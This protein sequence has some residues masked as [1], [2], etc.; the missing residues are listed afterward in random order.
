MYTCFHAEYGQKWPAQCLIGPQ[1][2]KWCYI[3]CWM[4]VSCRYNVYVVFRFFFWV[5]EPV[6]ADNQ[7]LYKLGGGWWATLQTTHWKWYMQMQQQYSKE[8]LQLSLPHCCPCCC[9]CRLATWDTG[10]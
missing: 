4:H 1:A 5:Q 6:Y 2:G 9:H 10:L 7:A 8:R 3:T